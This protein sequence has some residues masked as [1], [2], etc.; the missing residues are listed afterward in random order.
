MEVRKRE[1][2]LITIQ[3]VHTGQVKAY[4]NGEILFQDE[5]GMIIEAPVENL[6]NSF[7]EAMRAYRYNTFLE[8]RKKFTQPKLN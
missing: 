3:G 2:Y 6:F 4:R 5:R 8:N 1:M 7:S